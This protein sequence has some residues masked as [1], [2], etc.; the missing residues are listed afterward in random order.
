MSLVATVMRASHVVWILAFAALAC[1][2]ASDETRRPGRTE[3]PAPGEEPLETATIG[4]DEVQTLPV[5]RRGRS[6]SGRP[7]AWSSAWQKDDV[8]NPLLAGVGGVPMPV[9]V[10]DADILVRGDRP[11]TSEIVAEIIIGPEGN[12]LEATIVRSAEPRWPEAEE[13]ILEAVRQW[14]YEPMSLDG[15]PISVCSTLMLTL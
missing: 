9:K 5:E 13:A 12:V 6:A 3:K 4:N 15:T 14:K 7:C 8:P 1:R 10:A 2:P 11:G